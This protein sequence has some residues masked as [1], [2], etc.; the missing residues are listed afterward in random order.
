ME[1]EADPNCFVDTD[2]DDMPPVRRKGDIRNF[3][4]AAAAAN[5]A[6]VKRSSSSGSAPVTVPMPR[7]PA[8][9]AA[10][11]SKAASGGMLGAFN[12]SI[13][14]VQDVAKQSLLV[15]VAGQG[16]ELL[17]GSDE[18]TC[19]SSLPGR[20]E[21]AVLGSLAAL[22]D[23]EEA[24][25][26]L[27]ATLP[28]L[29]SGRAIT[30]QLPKQWLDVCGRSDA[31]GTRC[32]FASRR[33][34]HSVFA[35]LEPGNLLKIPA[36]VQQWQPPVKMP[37]DAMALATLADEA[38]WL[39][40]INRS[41]ALRVLIR[42]GVLLMR[43]LRRGTALPAARFIW[44]VVDNEASSA[45]GLATAARPASAESMGEFSLLSN[46]EDPAHTQPPSFQEFPLRREQL[47]SLGWMVNQER[48]RTEPFVTE[49]RD[50]VACPDAQH[51]RLEGSLRCE[52]HGVK[53]GVLADSIGYGK[54]ACTIGLIDCTSTEQLPIVPHP[55]KGFIPSRATLVL[56]PTNL[57]SQWVGEIK[58]FTGDS[59]KVLSVPT[60]AQLKR[61]TLKELAEADVVV[62]TY[63]LF[64]SSAYLKRLQ[65]LAREHVPGFTF[66]R[67]AG[68][69]ITGE[70]SRAYRKAFEA[71]P[72][73]Y[74]ALLG[75]GTVA[76]ETPVTPARPHSR[77]ASTAAAEE[78][79][80][81]M[82][83]R[84]SRSGR[85]QESESSQATKKRR[86]TGKQAADI[87]VPERP[88]DVQKWPAAALEASYVPLEAFWW[89]RVVCDEFHELLS[90][91]PPA[92]VAVELF[93]GDYKWGLSGT[94]PCQTLGQ[95]RKAASFLGVQIPA[96][97]AAASSEGGEEAYAADARQAAQEWLDAFVRR[98]TSE[99]PPL[100]EEERIVAV[101][102]TP[103]E[104]ALYLALT[105]HHNR[106]EAARLSCDVPPE[107][108]NAGR[109]AAS[110]LKL[111]SHFCA[112]GAA[113]VLTAEDEC[114]RQVAIRKEKVRIAEKE[115]RTLA[116]KAAASAQWVRHFEPWYLRQ[117]DA[118]TCGHIC[119]EGKASVLARLKFLN[120]ADATAAK[121]PK[122][123]LLKRLFQAAG[124]V[125][126]GM[127][128]MAL[129]ADFNAKAA[130][131]ADTASLGQTAVAWA[132]LESA[133]A[134][135]EPTGC[136]GRKFALTM[137]KEALAGLCAE[138]PTRCV[139]LRTQLEM[140]KFPGREEPGSGRKALEEENW[141]WLSEA[142]NALQLRESTAAWKADV[143]RC[144]T[145]LLA[146]Q[147]EVKD[148][149]QNLSSF[150]DTL[151]SQMEID[152]E[153]DDLEPPQPLFEKFGSKIKVLVRHV[154]KL[155]KEDPGCKLICF[156]QW[157][158][159]KR[160]IS[161]ALTEFEVEHLTLHGSVWARRAALMKFQF[162]ANSPRML[163]LSLEESASGT[164]L[165]AANHVLIV[166]PMEAATRE[167]AVAF[168]M[169]AVGR[170]R[171]PGQ[172]RKIHIWRFVTVGTIE[173]TITEDHQ[174]ELWER[175]RARIL[176]SQAE[177][178]ELAEESDMEMEEEV[179]DLEEEAHDSCTQAANGFQEDL[180]TQCYMPVDRARSSS[181]R[182][183]AIQKGIE[184]DSEEEGYQDKDAL[185]FPGIAG[186]FSIEASQSCI[187]ADATLS[188][189]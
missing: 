168:E 56:A 100:E 69:A 10:A 91:Y 125:D 39:T 92:Q 95:I 139:R 157:E 78:T 77:R 12:L 107:L 132:A 25:P 166:H 138:P 28:L 83:E 70:W 144:G 53:G 35:A 113:D 30:A 37:S 181:S 148:K 59:L 55:F 74:G 175:Q 24:V 118:A 186:G 119:A 68:Q 158:D 57:H 142:Q 88:Q 80:Q 165:T 50:F 163:L 173:Q 121:A 171:R 104:R 116:E 188:Y 20:L 32:L 5:L 183:A 98:N 153:A 109:S 146:L 15:A 179:E 164:N 180:S 114:E 2:G 110:L 178:C 122:S 137:V 123:E 11:P 47:R 136:P 169:Q 82:Q 65:E 1:L 8:T 126:E 151:A 36:A 108:Y 141:A 160:K 87:P 105:E 96:A 86:L 85:Q 112:S 131:A 102:Q 45:S 129:R 49:L 41:G 127:K 17:A 115:A 94:P 7:M 34:E 187:D 18:E 170:V 75:Q 63:R 9:P 3:F 51:W 90:R 52:Y 182:P 62:A 79:P 4:D 97:S 130:K 13:S 23:I 156:V 120:A 189:L 22:A 150:Q 40:Q 64:Y 135:G 89:R 111:C 101:R 159:L 177:P 162:E 29:P 14:T 46:L 167:E 134:A 61:L 106:G 176:V 71:L 149:L 145:R 19:P 6:G 73:W 152:V 185:P 16:G 26:L 72:H 172:Q 124:K 184:T 154:Q 147:A 42:P 43:M 76:E 54:T 31:L 133:A 27:E 81:D 93:H 99:L 174:R 66:P 58:K 128:D 44:R 84:Q 67:R 38:P 21:T 155:Q 143:E 103:K 48:R 117:P 140:P 60:C 33:H 161:S